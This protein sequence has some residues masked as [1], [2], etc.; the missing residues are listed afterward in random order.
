MNDHAPGPALPPVVD[1]KTWQDAREAL[2]AREKAHTREGDAIA[3]ARRRLPMVE[4]D[5]TIEVIGPDGPITILDV[6][7]GRKQLIAYFHAWWPGRPAAGQCEGCTFF[8]SQIREL[9]YLHSHD[10]MYATLCKGPYEVSVRY[11]DFMGLDMPWYSVEKTAAQLLEGRDWQSH[12][13]VCY[14]RDGERV[15]E[16]Y[17]TGGRGVE[18]MAPTL[19]L[20]DMTV[21]GRQETWEDSPDGWPQPWGDDRNSEIWRSNGRPIA[22]WSRIEAGRSDELT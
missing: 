18:I 3:A 22:Q 7:E 10:A 20:L 13:L 15:F 21:Y 14:V 11:R 17:Y 5:A 8:N 6:F 1:R 2:F 12:H 4:V 16:T 9:A 19:G